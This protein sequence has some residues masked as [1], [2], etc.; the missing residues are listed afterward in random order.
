ME[1]RFAL[2]RREAVLETDVRALDNAIEHACPCE[3]GYERLLR[4]R[5]VAAKQLNTVRL[6]LQILVSQEYHRV[7]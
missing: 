6:D 4:E 3:I 7:A 1:P 5:R 2:R